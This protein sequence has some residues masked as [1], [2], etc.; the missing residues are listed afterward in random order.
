M[1]SSLPPTGAEKKPTDQN[2]F[3]QSICLIQGKRWR[4]ARLVFSR[5]GRLGTTLKTKPR[6]RRARRGRVA[7]AYG[8]DAR[9]TPQQVSRRVKRR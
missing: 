8:G 4:S 7:V 1:P 9:H 3:R 5:S 2:A 6:C